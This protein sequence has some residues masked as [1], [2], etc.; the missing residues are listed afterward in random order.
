[1]KI[2]VTVLFISAVISGFNAKK[3]TECELAV[4][5]VQH[6]F[7]RASINDWVCL[8]KSES[9][10]DTKLTNIYNKDGSKDWGLFQI[11]DR[12]W[13]KGSARSKNVC[14][15]NCKSKFLN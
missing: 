4:E 3:Y 7:P 6:G 12:Y 5:L 9:G 2:F 15:F 14:G 10:M 11:N 8:V 13:C 1:M